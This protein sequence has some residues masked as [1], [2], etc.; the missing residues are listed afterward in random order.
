MLGFNNDIRQ[1]QTMM[2][3]K[4][5]QINRLGSSV[6]PQPFSP[7]KQ[8]DPPYYSAPQANVEIAGRK[9]S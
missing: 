1:T 2:Q 9:N 8:E 6:G 7:K 5:R 3:L 4:K